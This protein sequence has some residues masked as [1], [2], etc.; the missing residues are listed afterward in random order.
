M[1]LLDALWDVTFMKF[2][3][4][5][6]RIFLRP[7]FIFWLLWYLTRASR[8]AAWLAATARVS[9]AVV[10]VGMDNF[11]LDQ[12]TDTGQ[13]LYH[14]LGS[15]LEKTRIFSIQHGQDLRR[16]PV[17]Q[18][19]SKVTLLCWGG[20]VAEN[21][22][23]FGRREE[24][25]LIVGALV[26]GLYRKE[27][28]KEIAKDVKIC[29]VSTVKEDIW[30][31]SIIGERRAGYEA[32]V[33][34]L[35][36]F[37]DNNGIT[38]HIALTTRRDQNEE[39]DEVDIERKWFLQRLGNAISFTDPTNLF[40]INGIQDV[41]IRKPTH[42]YE[43]YS[44]YYLCDRSEVS[45]GMSSSV[46]WESFGRG[47]KILAVNL[48]DNPIYDFPIPGIWSLRQPTYLEFEIQLRR[49]LEMSDLEWDRESREAREY[50]ISYDPENPPHVAINRKIRESLS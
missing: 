13:T 33:K 6:R 37:Q 26:D 28:P 36:L 34:Y 22:P 32:L 12:H 41:S 42:V 20:W 1:A 16:F 5:D 45:L 40:G 50:L 3:T 49:I 38:P 43:R 19:T 2:D 15:L 23:L 18:E 8:L 46:L 25:F 30:W 35:K 4:Q 24:N 39:I 11:D 48:T 27:R 7:K 47:N 21:F 31:G 29:F 10:V 17:G 44:S 14:E 9:G